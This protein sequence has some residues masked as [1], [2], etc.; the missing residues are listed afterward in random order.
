[1]NNCTLTGNSA[2]YGGGSYN[3]NL[4]N[5]ILYYNSA[6][7]GPNYAYGS[8][9][10]C[11]TTPLPPQGL[12]N[13]DS[14]PQLADSAHI[15]A[16][17]PC[18]GAANPA[19]VTSLDIDGENWANPPSIGCDEY[20]AGSITGG[21]SVSIQGD[22]TNIATGFAAN[23]TGRINGHASS[24]RWD[25]GDGTGLTNRL[26]ASHNWN[27]PGDYALVFWAYNETFT[28]GVSATLTVHVV[29]PPIHYVRVLSPTPVSPFTSWATAA[30]TIQDAVDAA[31]L[32]GA[33]VLV[34]N[35]NYSAGGAYLNLPSGSNRVAVT[36]PLSV[37][38]VNGPSVT[39]IRGRQNYDQNDLRCVYLTNGAA[40]SGFTLTGGGATYYYSDQNGGGVWCS[41]G[42]VVSN[43][44]L[45]GNVAASSGGGAF[46]GSL[47]GCLL[48]SNVCYANAAAYGATLS[49]CTLSNN[50]GYGASSS[51]LTNCLLIGNSSGVDASVLRDCSLMNH[52]NTAA[53]NS[54]LEHCSLQSNSVGASSSILRNCLLA[55]NLWY[56]ASGSTLDN[57][58][59]SGTSGTGAAS[60][61]LNR[62]LITG[63]LGDGADYCSLNVCAL[64]GNHGTAANSCTLNHCNVTGNSGLGVAY[65]TLS[66]SIVYYNLAGNFSTDAGTFIPGAFDHCCTTPL[67]SGGTGNISAEPLLTDFLHITASSPCRGAGSA[68]T[69]S[70]VDIDGESW[71]SPPSIGCDEFY[72]GPVTGP[73]SVAIQANF[74][75]VAAGFEVTLTSSITGRA[76][77][78]RWDF[79]DGS[80]ADNRPFTHH[81]WTNGGDYTVAF[82]AFNDS[83]PGGVG[84]T[85]TIHVL[86]DPVYHVSLQSSNPVPPYLSWATA[87]TNIQD[88]VNV[89]YAG[90]T[91]VVS[92][93]TYRLGSVDGYRLEALT[94]IGIRSVNGAAATLIDGA[95]LVNCAYVSNGVVLTGFTLTNGLLGLDC[96][97]TNNLVFNCVVVSNVSGGVYGGMLSNCVVSGN[98]LNYT[99]YGGGA[100]SSTLEH[101]VLQGNV[102]YYGGGAYYCTLE[103]CTLSNNTSF[104]GGG[105]AENSTLSNCTILGNSSPYGYGGGVEGSTLQNCS[106][107]GNAAESGGGV[108][109]CTLTNCY[110]L[111]NSS[112]NGSGGGAGGSILYGCVLSGNFATNGYGGGAYYC[113]LFNCT[114]SGNS[115]Y[116]GGG[117]YS[118]YYTPLTNCIVYYNQALSTGDNYS[119]YAPAFYSSC[120]TPLPAGS[121]A[122]FTSPPAFA[123][124]ATGNLRLLS[125]SPC[126]NTGDNTAVVTSVDIDGRPRVVGGRVDVGAYEYQGPRISDFIA[127]LLAHGLSAD[128]SDDFTDPDGDHFSNWQEFLA[129]SNPND[130]SSA[131]PLI[132]GQPIGLV[133]AVGS[134]PS[135]S[136]TATGTTPLSYQWVFNDTNQIH[137]ATNWSL[138]L[139]NA[140]TSN[141]G[142]YSVR[143][144]NIFGSALSSNVLLMVDHPP[145]ADASATVSPV[146]SPNGSNAVVILD[147]S[148]SSDSDGDPL[149]YAWYKTGTQAPLASGVV[150]VK[151]LPVGSYPIQ[152]VVSDG[153][154]SDTNAIV[155][156][157][158]TVLDALQRL[159]NL[160]VARVSKPA[161]LR[162]T[163]AAAIASLVRGNTIAT[164][165]QLLAFQNKVRAQVASSDPA[166]AALLTQKAQDIIAVLSGGNTNPD[167]RPHGTLA[168][169]HQ[170]AKGHVQISFASPAPG[171]YIIEAS[172]NLGD[173][174]AVGIATVQSDGSFAFEDSDAGRFSRRFYR[175]VAPQP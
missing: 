60:C 59:I 17:S 9:N 148:R 32:P 99:Y 71:L 46:G 119:G 43:C 10:Y 27:V 173:W 15:S 77:S 33:I 129:G 64:V 116:E 108:S 51:A 170:K 110:L 35:G 151:V 169:L 2:T 56:G 128:G 130:A 63:S 103:D 132:T 150:A 112:T 94:P 171:P 115:A 47:L 111:G 79:G 20:H 100:N 3:V 131:P 31:S 8:L 143:V 6:N 101:C 26:F 93:G 45:F 107:V 139:S 174:E 163:L 144:T 62:C 172:S 58:I 123:N 140:Q 166:L 160:V 19:Y 24:N 152:L 5:S 72:A 18:R 22:Y 118:D 162:A 83:F 95:G 67:P 122:S 16:G 37:L 74:T 126:I 54:T 109:A 49:A 39:T 89:A 30:R 165:N 121:V 90:G 98:G 146:I 157:V 87:A 76:S 117:I 68:S 73:L 11:C 149:Q 53:W 86:V 158:I 80:F 97:S 28:N 156:E 1:L 66:N 141:A 114:V 154:F 52:A 25:F 42:S 159:D 7:S 135:F 106:L 84:A 81:H 145:K 23:F 113:A 175:I 61:T 50:V 168:S 164:V 134:N 4:T 153:S 48:S 104:Y 137:G 78:N 40:L 57:C 65:S 136:V 127:W 36:K 13:I 138:T 55:G 96:Y 70:G 12:G 29:A 21:L 82:R 38:S 102:S 92:N 69:T 125:N 120:T 133:A 142:L 155:V 105:G 75:N 41:P 91:V 44:I 161:P 14:E 167:G 147:A 34:T 85:L 88:A 124:L